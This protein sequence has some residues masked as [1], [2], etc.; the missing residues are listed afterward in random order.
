MESLTWTFIGLCRN[1][2]NTCFP[3]HAEAETY[4]HIDRYISD[5]EC[6]LKSDFS[7]DSNL[8]FQVYFRA[9]MNGPT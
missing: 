3:E 2:K 8:P 6:L 4:K 9:K 1:C 5:E 7:P